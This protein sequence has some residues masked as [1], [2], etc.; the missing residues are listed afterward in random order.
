MAT[1][2][3]SGNIPVFSQMP[4]RVRPRLYSAAEAMGYRSAHRRIRR[5]R[6]RAALQLCVDCTA[7]ADTWSYNGNSPFEQ[8]GTTRKKQKT[9]VVIQIPVT[10]SACV[11]DYSPRCY[12]CHRK[13][14]A[15]KES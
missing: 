14:D 11:Q 15:P 1:F 10:W 7:P 13:F 6:G 12:S 9:G 4:R 8:S 5:T 3:V 2:D